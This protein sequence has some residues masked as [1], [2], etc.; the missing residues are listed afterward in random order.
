MTVR[1]Q[2]ID[3][4]NRAETVGV[5][6]YPTKRWG[7][8]ARSE[9]FTALHYYFNADG[10]ELGYTSF[11]GDLCEGIVLFETPRVWSPEFKKNMH[12]RVSI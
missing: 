12:M 3:L 4:Q 10:T 5:M 1:E 6:M 2:I 9:A 8:P 7:Q 11:E